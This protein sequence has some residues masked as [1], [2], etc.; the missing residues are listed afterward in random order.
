VFHPKG[1]TFL[2]LARQ[3]L[4]STKRGYDLIAQKFDF[5]PFRTPDA[6]LDVVGK[7]LAKDKAEGARFASGLD[8]CCGTGAGVRMLRRVCDRVTGLDFSEGMLAEARRQLEKEEG[9]PFELLTGDALDL[10]YERA[11]DVVTCF[12]AFGHILEKDEPRFVRGIHRALREGGRFV[13]VTTPMPERW[14]RPWLFA[15]TYNG[16]THVRNFLLKPEFIMFYLTLT[17]ET[18]KALLER[19]GFDVEVRAG[20]FAEPYGRGVMVLATR[21][22]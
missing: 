17:L 14:S 18:S 13:Y 8:L 16:V 6:V 15:R 21:R 22:R 3:G 12:G 1:P 10:K 11:F 5:T 4:S 20:V 19:E 7:E 2:E 9:A